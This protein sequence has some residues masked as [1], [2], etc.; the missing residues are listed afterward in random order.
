MK[1]LMTTTLIVTFLGSMADASISD[2]NLPFLTSPLDVQNC[3]PQNTQDVLRR[4][5]LAMEEFN[6]GFSK[7]LAIPDEERTFENTIK[8]LDIIKG[9][10]TNAMTFFEGM[11]LVHTDDGIRNESDLARRE[12]KIM[13]FD[14]LS[15]GTGLYQAVM[16]VKEK[17]ENLPEHHQYYL[18]EM[19]L[20][21]QR[22]GLNLPDDRRQEAKSLRNALTLSAQDFR[23]N[24]QQDHPSIFVSKEDLDG[25]KSDFIDA[26]EKNEKGEYKLSCDYPIYFPVMEHCKVAKTRKAMY[27]LFS[28]RAFPVNEGILEEMIEKRDALAKVLGF[29]SFAAYELSGQ[30]VKTQEKADS[31]L[32]ELYQKSA[33]K[34]SQEFTVMTKE[35]PEGVKLTADG[36][37]NAYDSAFVAN[38][39]KMNHFKVDE[40]LISEYFPLE[41]TVQGLISIYEKF[42]NLS[43]NE[44]PNVKFWDKDVKLLQISEKDSNQ[45]LGYLLLD[46]FPRE[47]KYGHACECVL[48]PSYNSSDQKKHAALSLVVANFTKPTLSRPSLMNHDEARI[49]F[50]EFGHAIH[51]ILG[52]GDMI[53]MC[54]T[55]VKTD[56]VELPSQLLEEWLWDKDILK[57]ISSHYLTNQPL[58]DELID[59]MIK[60]RNCNS[61]QWLQRQCFLSEL[62]LEYFKE[63]AKKNTTK[64]LHDIRSKMISQY[65][66]GERDHFQ[67]S[68]GH[69]D[70][71]GPMYYGYLWSRVFAADV[72]EKIKQQGLLNPKAGAQYVSEIIGKGGSADPNAMLIKFLGREPSKE[73][74]M[75][76]LG[77]D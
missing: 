29:D 33:L 62:S 65:L 57:M 54:G 12:L 38:Y 47:N 18:D 20:E 2:D 56:F 48:F 16:R 22:F 41:K 66:F 76:N 51:E 70:E 15:S 44:V 49:F 58:P 26:L 23:K 13:F 68:F 32:K 11:S 24:I 5:T 7:V 25:L 39:Y 45:T 14:A 36:K 21:L 4:K 34:A 75:K 30:M 74:F 42:F 71:Y 31:F 73:A 37:L 8:A 6:E 72:F 64:M 27:E 17:K 40:I 46:L 60:A 10:I 50:H 67:V 53:M 9:K 52:R 77:I 59:L 43:I 35:L 28:N 63:G 3:I 69:L 19:V 55:K 1:F 61:A